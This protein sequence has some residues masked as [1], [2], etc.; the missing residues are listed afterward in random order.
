MD[1]QGVLKNC[2]R[3]KLDDIQ[4]GILLFPLIERTGEEKYKK[5]LDWLMAVSYTHLR[6]PFGRFWTADGTYYRGIERPSA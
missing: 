4:P 6:C 5:A 1:D 3:G 2:D